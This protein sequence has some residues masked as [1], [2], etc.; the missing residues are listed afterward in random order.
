MGGVDCH[1]VRADRRPDVSLPGYGFSTPPATPCRNFWRTT[2]LWGVVR[3]KLL[4]YKKFA[5]QGGEWGDWRLLGEDM[6][7]L[8]NDCALLPS[9]EQESISSNVTSP[10]CD[11]GSS[12][13][14]TGSASLAQVRQGNGWIIKRKAPE[15][16]TE[17][18]PADA[19]HAGYCQL[20]VKSP[21][22]GPLPL[23]RPS[24]AI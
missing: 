2:N 21:A 7:R 8:A 6:E 16:S 1:R 22:A 14:M 12:L 20:S 4:G 11:C 5:A 10:C 19:F 24:T 3:Q 17:E 23:L 9:K 18:F 15:A 13:K